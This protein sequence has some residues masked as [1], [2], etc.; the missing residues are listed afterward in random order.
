MAEQVIKR[1]GF[2]C[3]RME[4]D[5][6][7]PARVLKEKQAP[8][9]DRTTTAAWCSRQ[10]RDV[11]EARLLECVEHN[12]E[13]LHRLVSWVG[14][15]DIERHMVRLGSSQ[16]PLATHPDWRYLWQDP[17]N[18]AWMEKGF[19][20]VGEAARRLGVRLSFHPG[21]FT[22]L[23]S[24]RPDVVERSIEEFEYH[25]DMIRWMGYGKTFQDFKCN[26]HISGRKGAQG[27]IDVLPRLSPEARN[28]ITIENDEM[29]WGLDESLKLVDHVALVL[30][31]HHHWVREGEYI[32]PN[33]PRIQQ[34]QDSWRGVR[35]VIHYSYS[36]DEWLPADFPHDHLPDME[37]LL[38]AGCKKQKLR[39]HS[40]MLP[41][42]VANDWALEHG[43][44]ADIMVEA[45]MKN[46]ASEQLWR[47]RLIRTGLGLP[48][49]LRSVPHLGDG[50]VLS[51][52][53][54]ARDPCT[55]L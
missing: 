30:D 4:P 38:A 47:R 20:K 16:I 28:T 50:T 32:W 36:R 21:Q 46:L 42:P 23:A 45:K 3:K 43:E 22:V 12:M 55:L 24:D 37:Q 5:Q 31:I 52:C 26:V 13:A 54:L 49:P 15:L 44:W 10:T 7:Q 39:A 25:A 33:D 2:A 27:I 9:L 34:I 11:A 1:I 29:S 8:Y 41:N 35:P 19:S 40:D 53:A 6:R 51:E 14:A 18:R 48:L 17:E